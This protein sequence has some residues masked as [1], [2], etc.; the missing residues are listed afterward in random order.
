MNLENNIAK[1]IGRLY[2]LITKN[3]NEHHQSASTGITADQF[4]LLTNLWRKDGI[5]QQ[6]LAS[7]LGRDRAS[8]TRM[9]DILEDQGI[10]TRIPDKDD[11][12]IKLLYLTKKGRELEKRATECSKHIIELIL[13]DFT[14][15]EQS[16]FEYLIRKAIKNLE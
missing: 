5:S 16:D 13:K 1:S 3:L 15:Q 11:L 14:S 10:V 9:A 12:R 6:K 8:V 2:Y 7:F 4:R